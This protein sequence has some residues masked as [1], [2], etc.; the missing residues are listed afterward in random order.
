MDKSEFCQDEVTGVQEFL[1]TFDRVFAV[2]TVDDAEK[3]RGL[4]Y[5]LGAENAL[6]DAAIVTLIE[7]RNAAKRARD[8]AAADSIRKYLAERAIIIEDSRDGTVRWKRK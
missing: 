2:A 4:G 3:L 7:E 8:F 5:N 6:D 1:Q